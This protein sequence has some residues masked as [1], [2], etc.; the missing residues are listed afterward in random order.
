M[1]LGKSFVALL[2]VI[3]LGV[4]TLHG[5]D[6]PARAPGESTPG[7]EDP[8][9]GGPFPPPRGD[10]PRDPGDRPGFGPPRS[11][12]HSPDGGSRGHGFGL[13]RFD[14]ERL[15][16]YDPEMYE[17]WKADADLE[18][19]TSE[20]GER[21]RRAPQEV[22]RTKIFEEL[23]QLVAKHFDIRQ[24]KRELELK[25]LEEQL[26]RMKDSVAKRLQ[27]KEEILRGRLDE[28]ISEKRTDF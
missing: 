12:M 23:K 5:Q 24:K 14:Y 18:R 27:S 8:R 26:D 1:T 15:K 7:G 16:D 20:L 19:Q 3:G 6:A 22:E 13:H 28:L 4:A 2:L 9:D 10:G 25:R 11:G 17:L 21:Y